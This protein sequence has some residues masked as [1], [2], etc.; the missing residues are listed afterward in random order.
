M[1]HTC[2]FLGSLVVAALLSSCTWQGMPFGSSAS[3]DPFG[4][5]H[6][7]YLKSLAVVQPRLEKEIATGGAYK[8]GLENSQQFMSA[9]SVLVKL[10]GD[11]HAPSMTLLGESI[12]YEVRQ[13][14]IMTKEEKLLH[15]AEP[16]NIPLGAVEKRMADL[17]GVGRLLLTRAAE[18]GYDPA[19]SALEKWGFSEGPVLRE[20]SDHRFLLV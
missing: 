9:V 12:L 20:P 18:M 2:I 3:P 8:P 13:F 6:P 15:Y 17:G 4:E 14:G 5:K 1:K 11:G 19:A 7:D 10:S 16:M